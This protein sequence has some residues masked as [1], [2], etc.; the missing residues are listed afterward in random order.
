MIGSSVRYARV[1]LRG[2][3]TFVQLAPDGSAQPLSQAP[4]A[5]NS[6]EVAQQQEQRLPASALEG[7]WL[8]PVTPSKIIG[9]GRN[10]RKHAEELKN[11][12]PEEPLMFFKPPSSLIAPGGTVL[13]PPESQRVDHEGELAVVLGRRVRRAGLDEARRAIFGYGVACDVT[14]RDLQTKDKQWT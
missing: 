11:E 2:V 5:G 1:S 9:I 13:L 3:P 4:W 6:P 14:A 12:V 10:Y 8:C 7:A